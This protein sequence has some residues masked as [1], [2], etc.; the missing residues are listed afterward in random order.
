MKLGLNILIFLFFKL[1]HVNHVISQETTDLSL[2]YKEIILEQTEPTSN[3]LKVVNTDSVKELNFRLLVS[4]PNNWKFLGDKSFIYSLKPLD[5]IFLPIRLIPATDFRG[6]VRYFIS[7]FIEDADKEVV[8]NSLSFQISKKLKSEWE[9]SV[10]SKERTIFKNKLYLKN[11]EKE[12]NVNYNIHN[13]GTEDEDLIFKIETLRAENL[14]FMDSLNKPLK[15]TVFYYPLAKYRDTTL[16]F[17]VLIKDRVRNMKRISTDYAD[18]NNKLEKYQILASTKQ[19]KFFNTGEKKNSMLTIV[20]LPN[21]IKEHPYSKRVYPLSFYSTISNIGFKPIFNNLAFGSAL[22][23]NKALLNY[24]LQHFYGFGNKFSFQDLFLSISY[25]KNRY[26]INTGPLNA[27]QV[28]G[29][30]VRVT[31]KFNKFQLSNSVVVA[32]RLSN[33]RGLGVQSSIR[34]RPFSWL[35]LSGSAGISLLDSNRQRTNVINLGIDLG[36]TENQTISLDYSQF[37]INS[38]NPIN[39]ISGVSRFVFLNYRINYLK[40][41]MT[42]LGT[43]FNNPVIGAVGFAGQRRRNLTHNTN[44]VKNKWNITLI[45][46]YVSVDSISP[47]FLGYFRL[48]NTLRVQGELFGKHFQPQFFHN[49]TRTSVRRLINQGVQHSFSKVDNNRNILHSFQF[50]LGRQILTSLDTNVLSSTNP[51]VAL[52]YNLRYRT[53]NIIASYLRGV[54]SGIYSNSNNINNFFTTVSNQYQ[55]KNPRWII[56]NN[57]SM[58]LNS[59][60]SFSYNP[61]L[62]YFTKNDFRLSLQPGFNWTKNRQNEAFFVGM[63]NM[64]IPASSSLFLNFSIQKDFAIANPKAE[65][66]FSTVKVV[67]FFDHNGNQIIDNNEEIIENVIVEMGNN[68]CMTNKKG[69]AIFYNVF[70]DSSYNLKITPIEDVRDY[71]PNYN[72]KIN[73][74]KDTTLFIPFVKGVTIYGEIYVD[75]DIYSSSFGNNFDLSNLRVSAFNGLD[76]HTLTD[77]KGKF[78]MYVP[79]GEYTISIQNDIFGNKLKALENNFEVVLNES[80]NKIFVSFYLVEKRKKITIKKF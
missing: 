1:F 13:V 60:I 66:I 17:N 79:Y 2:K 80:V 46:N 28:Q 6:D 43:S 77:S 3:I 41:F 7:C 53:W 19:N 30:G 56:N 47:L 37:G 78:E 27:A 29:R 72:N 63:E 12:L 74:I 48:N 20:H 68:Q 73:T 34:Y 25:S 59:R 54:V 14:T 65:K 71:F 18:L 11:H 61:R 26:S 75:K 67:T 35:G 33:P 45:N 23:K 8:I 15:N 50:R 52:N 38:T 16:S 57:L 31:N 4:H 76:V 9:L 62:F 42:S 21:S 58:R 40:N 39:S 5:S 64:Q 24:R 32:P 44:Y 49:I 22:L 36:I 51:T 70:K 69:E 55:F 10:F